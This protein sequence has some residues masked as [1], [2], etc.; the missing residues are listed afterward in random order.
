MF[1]Y[2]SFFFS[3]FFF[4]CQG[5]TSPCVTEVNILW[6]KHLLFYQETRY[7]LLRLRPGQRASWIGYAISYHLLKDY[8]MAFT[9][10]EDFRKTQ[11]VS[12]KLYMGKCLTRLFN[13]CPCLELKNRDVCTFTLFVDRFVYMFFKMY[14]RSSLEHFRTRVWDNYANRQVKQ[15]H[16]PQYIE[17][18]KWEG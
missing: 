17:M 5:F 15:R 6:M 3:V 9:I 4:F 1:A 14:H 16:W 7:Q 8:D 18:Y 10:L 2:L 12:D 11:H 13:C